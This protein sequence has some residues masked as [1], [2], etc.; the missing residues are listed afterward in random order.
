MADSPASNLGADTKENHE[1]R[2]SPQ[3]MKTGFRMGGP[4]PGRFATLSGQVSLIGFVGLLGQGPRQ[5][6]FMVFLAVMQA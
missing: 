1:N 5:P 2:L 3:T 6:V 4:L